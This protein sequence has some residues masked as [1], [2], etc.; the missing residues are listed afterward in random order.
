[1]N[2]HSSLPGWGRPGLS[3][4]GT[5][6]SDARGRQL[7]FRPVTSAEQVHCLDSTDFN[8]PW[9]ENHNGTGIPLLANAIPS[10][11]LVEALK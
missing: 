6:P 3:H 4:S 8:L 9:Y 10:R 2:N 5:K 11:E 1:M 7:R